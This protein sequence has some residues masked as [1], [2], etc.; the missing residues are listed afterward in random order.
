MKRLSEVL[1][2]ACALSGKRAVSTDSTRSVADSGQGTTLADACSICAGAG[3]VYHDLP[4]AHPDRSKAFPCDC[5]KPR[6]QERLFR[7]SLVPAHFAEW[8]LDTYPQS[9]ATRQSWLEVV[10]W[11]AIAP[12][13]SLYLWGPLGTGKTGMAIGIIRHRVFK[14]E[15]CL[16]VKTPELL[17]RIR[18][19]YNKSSDEQERDVVEAVKTAAFLVLDDLGSERSTDWVAEQLFRVVDYRHDH[20][21]PTVFTSNL[22]LPELA[23]HLD[24]RTA[25]RIGE[26]SQQVELRGPNLR[27]RK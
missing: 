5:I 3:W 22:S 7:Q 25:N 19:N 1:P 9:P 24:A 13:P 20:V 8:T 17:A 2:S 15:S 11:L 12:R 16:F 27:V 23:D 4:M 10:N 21:L 26:M 14:L 6:L 18:E